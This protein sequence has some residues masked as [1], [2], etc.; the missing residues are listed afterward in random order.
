LSANLNNV[1]VT[2]IPGPAGGLQLEVLPDP[3]IGCPDDPGPM[4]IMMIMMMIIIIII[5]PIRGSPDRRNTPFR[6]TSVTFRND[7]SPDDQ[8]CV[9]S[10]W[11]S[12]LRLLGCRD[13]CGV[14]TDCTR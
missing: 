2:V 7:E 13:A 14:H 3:I 10:Q 1:T 9:G 12:M 4:I 5:M 6:D 11:A 8:L